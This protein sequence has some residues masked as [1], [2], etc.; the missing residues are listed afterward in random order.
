MCVCAKEIQHISTHKLKNNKK[1]VI[2]R[3]SEREFKDG[4][5]ILQKQT[6]EC[7]ELCNVQ[8]ECL[9]YKGFSA[10]LRWLDDAFKFK[11]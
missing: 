11:S 4:N 5:L 7:T 10:F 3:H 8:M 9:Q 2:R 1:N 6:M